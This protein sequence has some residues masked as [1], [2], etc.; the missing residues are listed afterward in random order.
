MAHDA[1]D[2]SDVSPG[3]KDLVHSYFDGL[4]GQ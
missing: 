1:I 2:N 3:T 4:E